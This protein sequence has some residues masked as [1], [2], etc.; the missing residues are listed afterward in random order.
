M[1]CISIDPTEQ[2][3]LMTRGGAWTFPSGMPPAGIATAAVALAEGEIR[4]DVNFGW[5]YRALPTAT[6]A[7]T[8]TPAPTLTATATPTAAVTATATISR[9]TH[10]AEH[11]SSPAPRITDLAGHIRQRR[12]LAPL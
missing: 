12:Q 7:P 2:D 11:R 8:G 4:G 9:V 5:A 10:A 3:V 1:Y 6:V